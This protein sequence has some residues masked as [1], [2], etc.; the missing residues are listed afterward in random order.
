MLPR[1][2][3]AIIL[4][5]LVLGLVA[6][7]TT[8]NDTADVKSPGSGP[9]IKPPDAEDIIKGPSDITV[10]MVPKLKAIPYFIATEKGAQEAAKETGVELLYD[11]PDSDRV[12]DQIELINS[13]IT[14]KVDAIA[15]APNDPVAIATVLKRARDEGIHVLTWDADANAE[16]SGREFFV[17]QAS[18]ESIGYAMVDVIAAEAGEDAKTIIISGSPT[19]ANQREWMKWMEKRMADKYPDMEVLATKFP[20]EDGQVAQQVTAD[21]LTGYAELDGIFAITSVAFPAAAK[22]LDDS[23]RAGEVALTGLAT[24][25]D[26]RKWVEKD[27]VKTVVLWNAVDLGYLTIHAAKALCEGA[28]EEGST[29]VEAGRLGT[30]TV[31]G[32]RVV[33]G[34]PLCFTKDNIGDYDF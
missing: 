19:A 4:L 24:P 10:A 20:G 11:G 2:L 3:T 33:L 25:N 15:V 13:F 17:D 26:M 16:K 6:G 23:G 5:A 12:E 8:K 14:R 1:Q 9:V 27:V 29:S 34:D 31:D 30:M 22:A 21:V 18:P 7:C 32:E 28:L